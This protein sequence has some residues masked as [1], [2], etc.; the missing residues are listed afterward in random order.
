MPIL[1]EQWPRAVRKVTARM[2]EP[3]LPN[4]RMFWISDL[5]PGALAKCIHAPNPFPQT[6]S[7][8]LNKG[9]ALFQQ[10]T[11]SLPCQPTPASKP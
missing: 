4:F 10:D 2:L 5:S 3:F 1:V 11:C 8:P 6:P 7:L 9:V